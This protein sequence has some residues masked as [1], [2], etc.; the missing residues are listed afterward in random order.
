MTCLGIGEEGKASG[1]PC[2]AHEHPCAGLVLAFGFCSLDCLSP[3]LGGL[4]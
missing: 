4:I 2:R 3:A 1:I